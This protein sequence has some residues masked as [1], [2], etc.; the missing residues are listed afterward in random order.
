MSDLSTDLARQIA[1]FVPLSN[2]G[3]AVFAASDH[4]MACNDA[5]AQLFAHQAHEILRMSFADLARDAF[6]RQQGIRIEHTDI[7]QWLA[8]AATKRRQ[9]DYRIFEVDLV[10]GRWFLFSE[11]ML[12]DGRLLIQTK[13]ITAQ[14][15][16]QRDLTD[17]LHSLRQLALTDELTQIA[18][19]RC[20]VDSV[21][22][23]LKRA[24]RQHFAVALL[25]LD[26]DFFKSINDRF[27]HQA[28][29]QVLRQVAAAIR[30]TLREY[31]IFGRIGGEEFAIFLSETDPETAQQV[32][33]RVRL[34]VA[35]QQIDFGRQQ[36]QVTVSAGLCCQQPPA[37]FEHMYDLADQAL[38][39]AKRQGR[40]Q[41]CLAPA[42]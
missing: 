2:D 10:D 24:L 15:L 13:E 21:N 1:D 42:N 19:R 7:E 17:G 18:N 34:V 3:Y 14:K 35:S 39:Q 22:T 30:Q 38:Y 4:I 33:E 23:E 5:F 11:Q 20:F 16:L 26:L 9:R 25:V 37:S 29:D 27:G 36:L 41:I 8:Q 6:Y 12:P 31:D 40:N 32:A 28:G